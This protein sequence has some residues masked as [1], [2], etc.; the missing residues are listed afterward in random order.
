M[1]RECLDQT[2]EA[3]QVLNVDVALRDSMK[4]AMRQLYPYQIGKKGNLQE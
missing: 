2:I 1:I 4:A 3:S